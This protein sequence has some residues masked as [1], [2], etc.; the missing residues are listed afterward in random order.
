MKKFYSAIF[1]MVEIKFPKSFYKRFPLLSSLYVISF[2]YKGNA[3]GNFLRATELYLT[4]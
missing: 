2:K 3:S 1:T 4:F